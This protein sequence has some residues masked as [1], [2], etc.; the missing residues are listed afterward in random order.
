MSQEQPD[1]GKRRRVTLMDLDLDRKDVSI[2]TL[3][4]TEQRGCLPC[5]SYVCSLLSACYEV[6]S[7]G[8]EQSVHVG[9][10]PDPTNSPQD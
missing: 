7:S 10:A 2:K 1:M 8:Q 9:T 5:S 3:M 4:T 6:T